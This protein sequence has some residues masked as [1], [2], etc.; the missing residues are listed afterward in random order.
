LDEINT[1]RWGDAGQTAAGPAGETGCGGWGDIRDIAIGTR[2]IA[3]L[4]VDPQQ[5]VAE[6]SLREDLYYRLNVVSL[7]LPPLRERKGDI[8]LLVSSFLAKYNRH[9]RPPNVKRVVT[10]EVMAIVS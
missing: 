3:T 2:V 10:P 5:A 1:L 9:S 7:R 8:P 6:G 4:S